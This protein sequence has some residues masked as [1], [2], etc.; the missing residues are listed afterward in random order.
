MSKVIVNNVPATNRNE[1]GYRN[2][3]ESHDHNVNQQNISDDILDLFNKANNIEKKVLD[4]ETYIKQET[5]YIEA[6][7]ATWLSIYKQLLQSVN[8]IVNDEVSRK[9]IVLPKDCKED[10]TYLSAVINR[11]TNCITP[12]YVTKVS[13]LSILDTITDKIYLPDTLGVFIQ[14]LTYSIISET[15]NDIYAP[16]DRSDDLYWVRDVVTDNTTDYVD[17]D[18]IINMP[19]EIMTS[20]LMNEIAIYPY[21]C[22]VINIQYRYGDSMSWNDI[23]GFEY[24]KI[25]NQQDFVITGP[26]QFNFA[27]VKANQVKITI[28]SHNYKESETD[29]RNFSFGL[30]HVGI[31]LCDYSDDEM[32]YLST[33]VK[34]D[35]E[36]CSIVISNI[37]AEF[38]NSDVNSHY[39]KDIQY[40]FF[41]KNN[42]GVYQYIAD[43]LPFII[44]SNEILIKLKIAEK[45]KNMNISHFCL[46]Y[47]VI[48][49]NYKIL[50]SFIDDILCDY[51]S[52]F[53]IYYSIKSSSTPNIKRVVGNMDNSDIVKHELSVDDGVTW[54]VIDPEFNGVRYKHTKAA[55]LQD[56]E[57]E[58]CYI[59]VTDFNGA[60]GIS[61][62]FKISAV[63]LDHAPKIDSPPSKIYTYVGKVVNIIYRAYDETGIV[64]HQFSEDGG[65]TWGSVNPT[66]TQ[67]QKEFN[68]FSKF[69]INR[70][71]NT[72]GN[73]LCQLRITDGLNGFI[74]SELFEIIVQPIPVTDFNITDSSVTINVGD[75]YK[76]PYVIL[77]TDA[78]DQ[79]VHWS[80]SNSKAAL[81]DNVGIVTGVNPGLSTI[82]GT[83]NDQG[84]VDSCDVIVKI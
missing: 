32:S 26:V 8:E 12:R 19:E 56:T 36:D 58:K 59:R 71:Y 43:S 57:Y 38:N 75:M 23:E 29:L 1:F 83:T 79:L 70:V 66:E 46:N 60:I 9:K 40:E 80:T 27:P 78:S 2:V 62:R 48:N 33:E 31:F 82:T 72:V 41:F 13:K 10:N 45:Y 30:K 5:S 76:I 42:K 67:P 53:S 84:I 39:Q 55:F 74:Y 18:Y 44:P 34:F 4:N 21:M 49:D 3:N 11:M 50:I 15:D 63:L 51:R 81:V 64:E 77:P 69:V 68:Y 65:Y 54:E 52:D 14:N 28:R 17:T 20:P 22:K 6:E 61:N 73:V 35:E 37:I 25:A 24:N 7:K 47:N 16:F